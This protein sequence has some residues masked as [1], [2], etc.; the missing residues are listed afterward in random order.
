MLTVLAVEVRWPTLATRAR[1]A[2][3]TALVLAAA[4]GTFVLLLSGAY[5]RGADASMACTTWPLCDDGA[6]P[7]FGAPAVH[8]AHRWVAAV[9]GVVLIAACWQAQQRA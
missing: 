8:M 9:V 2:P 6:F 7:A 3:W 5:V 4:V 1:G